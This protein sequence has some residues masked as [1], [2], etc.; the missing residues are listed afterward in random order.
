MPKKRLEIP[1]Q[2]AGGDLWTASEMVLNCR[3]AT[4]HNFLLDPNHLNGIASLRRNIDS[5]YVPCGGWLQS[6]SDA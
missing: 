1:Y 3:I 4:I 5:P 6:S 2:K